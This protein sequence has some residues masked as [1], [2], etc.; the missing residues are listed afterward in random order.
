MVMPGGRVELACIDAETLKRMLEEKYPKGALSMRIIMIVVM[1]LWL[2]GTSQSA[3]HASTMYG[4]GTV[5]S[6]TNDSIN[7]SGT[8]YSLHKKAHVGIYR[9]SGTKVNEETRSLSAIESG[10]EVRFKTYGNMVLEL[11][12]L[13]R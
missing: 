2:I 8:T 10:Q 1:A 12:I 9:K 11:I 7:I 13:K 3:V 5:I 6:V 4:T